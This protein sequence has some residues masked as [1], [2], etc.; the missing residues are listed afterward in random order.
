VLP[1]RG[2]ALAEFYAGACDKLHGIPYMEATAC[3]LPEPHGVT[4][5]VIRGITCKIL[6]QWAVP[7]LRAIFNGQT[8]QTLAYRFSGGEMAAEVGFRPVRSTST[9]GHGWVPARH[10]H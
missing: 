5:H 8:S 9:A 7:W 2:S 10:R 6:Y 4:G 3:W 1:I